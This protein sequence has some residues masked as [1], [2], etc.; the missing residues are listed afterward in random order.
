[1]RRVGILTLLLAAPWA[2]TSGDPVAPALRGVV[3]AP[4]GAPV[5]GARVVLRTSAGSCLLVPGRSFVTTITEADGTFTLPPAPE[6]MEVG[7]EHPDFSPAWEEARDGA[8]LRLGRPTYLAGTV[9]ATVELAV[10][11][12]L[13]PVARQVVAGAFRL[14][15]LPAGKTLT[16]AARSPRHRPFVRQLVIE[17]GA[18]VTLA[19]ALDEGLALDG[20]VVPPA[21]GIAVRASQGEARESAAT[22]DENGAFRLTGLREGPVCLVLLAPDR[23]PLVATARA[24][25][26]VEVRW[27]R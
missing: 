11:V 20:R 10:S 23:E 17:E 14:G 2:A 19:V 5:P 18:T 22:T 26:P 4:D 15:P 16:V 21:A 6:G 8:V 3:L 12:G 7:A 1:V 25:E 9:D 13:R 24:A 27:D